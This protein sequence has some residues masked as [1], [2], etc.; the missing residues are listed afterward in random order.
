MAANVEIKARVADLEQLERATVRLADRGPEILRQVDV[1][2]HAPRGRFKLRSFPEGHGELIFYQRPDLAGPK[3]S[4]YS[5]YQTADAEQLHGV[6]AATLG[7]A[8]TVRKERR[9]YLAGSTRIHLDRVEQ[10]G[11]FVEL[12]VVL[13]PR[14]T[15]AEGV[16]VASELMRSLGI[17]EE[18]LVQGAYFDLL[19]QRAAG[20]PVSEGGLSW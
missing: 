4:R 15:E 3:Q 1:F 7:V 16:A 2:F 10:L 19:H 13:Q 14:Q 5:I 20:P 8:G 18:D 6:L 12:E 9:L 11:S 17:R